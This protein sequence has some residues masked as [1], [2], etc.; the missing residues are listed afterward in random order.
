MWEKNEKLSNSQKPLHLKKKR[1]KFGK[2]ILKNQKNSSKKGDFQKNL[3]WLKNNDVGDHKKAGADVRRFEF[4]YCGSGRWILG[5]FLLGGKQL[6]SS[7]TVFP[8]NIFLNGESLIILVDKYEVIISEGSSFEHTSVAK[9]WSTLG[10]DCDLT[11]SSKLFSSSL[12]TIFVWS[13]LIV[14]IFSG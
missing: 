3:A 14:T 1:N 7:I 12:S 5:L 10:N 2:W 6:L 9:H 11:T 4:G 13:E 8:S